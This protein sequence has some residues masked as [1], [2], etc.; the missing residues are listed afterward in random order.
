MEFSRSD[1]E[2]NPPGGSRGSDHESL[3]SYRALLETSGS[4]EESQVEDYFED[5]IPLV[6]YSLRHQGV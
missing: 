4:I 3:R 1:I 2:W 5:G 6:Q